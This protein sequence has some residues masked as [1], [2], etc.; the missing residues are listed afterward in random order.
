M[1]IKVLGV[2]LAVL[3]FSGISLAENEEKVI[4]YYFHGN[5][6]CASCLKIEQYTKEALEKFFY[7]DITSGKIDFQVVNVEENGDEHYTQDYKLYT[8]SVV[9][10]RT[11]NGKE[12]AY[13][14]LEKV[15]QYLRNKEKF[16]EYIRLETEAI[17]KKDIAI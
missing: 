4:V 1:K 5:A 8:K 15:W 7:N 10:S 14:N 6:R 9:L 16:Y 11:E 17:L 12:I 13:K 3:L 2:L